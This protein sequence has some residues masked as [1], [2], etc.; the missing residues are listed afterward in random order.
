M[1]F[2]DEDEEARQ[3]AHD[4][5]SKNKDLF[6]DDGDSDSLTAMTGMIR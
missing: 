4:F 5:A 6:S 1:S 3:T 2:N